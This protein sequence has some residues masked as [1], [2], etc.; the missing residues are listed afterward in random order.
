MKSQFWEAAFF[1]DLGNSPATFEASRW[2]DFY[3]CLPGHGVKCVSKWCVRKLYVGK[4]CV[5]KWCVGE[6]CVSGVYE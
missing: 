5:G 2:A 3:G 6:L 1:Q 4:W